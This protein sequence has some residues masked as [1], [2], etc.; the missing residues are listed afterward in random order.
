MEKSILKVYAL[1][2]QLYFNNSSFIL[3]GNHEQ[4]EENIG[5]AV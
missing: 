2:F 3:E 1:K 5:N 4:N